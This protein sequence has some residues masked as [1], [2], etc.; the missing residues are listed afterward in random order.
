MSAWRNDS[1]QEVSL[2]LEP[3]VQP[4]L[5]FTRR[6]Y[7]PPGRIYT[8]TDR[9]Q[10]L[11]QSGNLQSS[12]SF[13]TE[14]I[15]PAASSWP[16]EITDLATWGD[17][18]STLNSLPDSLVSKSSF[19]SSFGLNLCSIPSF[20]TSQEAAKWR[21]S[22]RGEEDA[23]LLCHLP[24]LVVTYPGFLLQSDIFEL[25]CLSA[26]GLWPQ[27][28]LSLKIHLDLDMHQNAYSGFRSVMPEV[29]L[30]DGME[31]GQNER[32]FH[33]QIDW[34]CMWMPRGGLWLTEKLYIG[35]EVRG[36][37]RGF[38]IVNVVIV[39]KAFSQKRPQRDVEKG[40]EAS[41]SRTDS[42]EWRRKTRE[43]EERWIEGSSICTECLC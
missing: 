36:G 14:P 16:E 7:S 37:Q 35:T 28:C 4:W 26:K 13:S 10:V 15:Y 1:L 21:C 20:I 43:E 23:S 25:Q 9:L 39:T 40:K 17:L 2:G 30:N 8:P 42:S 41:G 33:S 5:Q 22:A 31:E 6:E 11:D 18:S 19:L 12:D 27:H 38:R 3:Q 34:A 24:G 29:I 32:F